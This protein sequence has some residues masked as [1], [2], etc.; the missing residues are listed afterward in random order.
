MKGELSFTS[1]LQFALLILFASVLYFGKSSADFYNSFYG[2]VDSWREVFTSIFNMEFW[3]KFITLPS[4]IYSTLFSDTVRIW[5]VTKYINA[6][7]AYFSFFA[8]V[9]LGFYLLYKFF[10]DFVPKIALNWQTFKY[11]YFILIAI[12]FAYTFFGGRYFGIKLIG[13][14]QAFWYTGFYS[15]TILIFGIRRI[16]MKPGH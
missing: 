4:V 14:S 1:K 7:V 3:I 11:S 2:K 6:S 8:F 15:L 10:K 12:F 16:R 5:N 13:K 9:V